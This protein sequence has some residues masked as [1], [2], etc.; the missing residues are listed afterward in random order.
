MKLTIDNLQGLGAQDYTTS[1]DGTV[2]P[3]V[4]RKIN[5]PVTF[6]CNLLAKSS[7]FVVPVA[8]ARV[9]VTRADGTFVFTGYLAAIPTV[10]YLGWGEQSPVYRYVLSAV[11]DEILLDRK[12]LPNRAPLVARTAGSALRQLAQ[13]LLPGF[14]NT[15]AVQ[16]VDVLASYAVNPGNRFSF[17]AAE[18]A[19]SARAAYRAV[20]GALI[21]APVG[22]ATYAIDESGANFSSG[23]LTLEC[24]NLIVND[25]TAIGM[26]EPQ[27]YVRNYF[28]GDGATLA[29][30]LSQSAMQQGVGALIDEQYLGPGLD[31]T[32]WNVNDPTS[33]FSVAAQ[34][35]VVNGGA[36]TDA[37][38]L[39]SFIEQIEMGGALELQHGE[40]S[41][42]AASQGV[43]GGLYAG[44]I[45]V[46]DC[47][48]GFQV[49]PSGIASSIQALV[50]GTPTGPMVTTTAG[51]RYVLTTYLYSR[52]IYRSGETYHSSLHPAGS[53]IGGIG[54]AGDVRIV[55]ELQ[56]VDPSSPA[57]LMAAATV[58]FDGVISN[59]REFCSYA[60]V[61]AIN[62]Q[63][64]VAFTYVAHISLAEVRVAP[65][66]SSYVTQLVASPSAGGQ[67]EIT[68]SG[69]LT[70][71][72]QYV[73]P[74][75]ASI[76]VSYRGAGRAAAEVV[77]SASVASLQ[78][79]ADDG[80]RGVVR[81]IKVPAARTQADCEN[82]AL[83]ILDDSVGPAWSGSYQTWSDFLPGT[84]NDIFPGDGVAVNA[85]SR[86]A[87]FDAIVRSLKIEMK[88]PANDRGVYT[89]EFANEAV[90]LLAMQD[91][92]IGTA[93][94][95]QD[96]P[97]RQ[98]TTQVGSYYVENLTD[99]QITG[100][101]ST[102]VSVDAGMALPT[103][104]GIEVRLHDFGWGISNDQNLLGRF[105]SETF[106]LP[107]LTRS[108]TYFLRL[109]DGSSS[110][111]RYSRYSA[112]LHIDIPLS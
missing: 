46:A 30:Y 1:L 93:I 51:H 58:L 73:P 109:Y 75:N 10:E 53:G 69:T 91:A 90:Q 52:E 54:V 70:F 85:P 25:V 67:C 56:E 78:N 5:Q 12:A 102:S 111:P 22:A 39:V 36:G 61:N 50:N 48:A 103:D 45:S 95:L 107:R 82:A 14:F 21:L 23:G 77:N 8:G 92:A 76:V 43:I 96:R 15:A 60:L 41:F 20:N 84:A 29:F 42:S 71:Y 105:S 16:D 104:F 57:S 27:D 18:I 59:A 31:P 79:G 37:T 97:V 3:T 47:V 62:M 87:T 98:T 81:E 35:L 38:T 40:V 26:N 86:N 80:T 2:A 106:T 68:G 74:L 63:C 4:V 49:M 17:H 110:P 19:L 24:K 64:S 72:P 88:D 34:A 13:D 9:S 100:F 7:G 11:S 101:S 94:L 89:I 6:T 66:G 83:A 33:A 55:L 65:S 32:T 108:Q 44:P 112:A 99:A 28:E